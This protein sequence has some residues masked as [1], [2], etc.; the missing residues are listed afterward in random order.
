MSV[1][2]Q[3]LRYCAVGA[4]N[5]LVSLALATILL[6]AGTPL[7]VASACAFA[8]GAVTGYALNRRWTFGARHSV[9][10][11]GVY[12]GVTLCGLGL[13]TALVHVIHGAGAS[14]LAAFVLA[15]PIVTLLTFAA[16]RRLTFRSALSR[17]AG[18]A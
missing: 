16:N 11:G 1:R 6:A 13:D 4:V 18:Y 9:S 10:A 12:A 5:T 14:A 2:R 3:I 8:T 15:L 7:L 17:D